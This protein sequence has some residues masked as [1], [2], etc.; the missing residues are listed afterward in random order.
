MLLICSEMN[1]KGYRY[2]QNDSL[3]TEA[4]IYCLER[5]R[6]SLKSAYKAKVIHSDYHSPVAFTKDQSFKINFCY[7]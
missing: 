4:E 2:K 6:K 5:K 7:S 3:I 1:L